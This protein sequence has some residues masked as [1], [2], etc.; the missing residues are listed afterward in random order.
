MLTA[1]MS[2]ALFSEAKGTKHMRVI[3]SR[4]WQP[5]KSNN[6]PQHKI[7]K[8]I[9]CITELRHCSNFL[10]CKRILKISSDNVKA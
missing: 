2:D 6:D 8:L 10:R 7:I 9:N 1:P 3:F 5:S 4:H